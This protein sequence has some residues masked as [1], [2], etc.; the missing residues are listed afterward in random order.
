MKKLFVP[1]ALVA[2]L[3]SATVLPSCKKSDD[4]GQSRA[5]M[6]VGDWNAYQTG[7]DSNNNGTWDANER[8]DVSITGDEGTLT[9]KSDGTGSANSNFGGT[10]VSLPVKWSLQNGDKDLRMIITFM[11][12][13]TTLLNIV[14]LTSSDMELRNMDDQPVS[15]TSFKKKS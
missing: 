5:A 2:A 1:A 3:L 14:T 13:D 7:V 9:L 10:P 6:L 15:Y 12:D 8:T 4:G 11:G